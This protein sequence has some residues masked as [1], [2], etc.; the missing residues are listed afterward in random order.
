MSKSNWSKVAVAEMRRPDGGI[1][2]LA[3]WRRICKACG[4]V[5]EEMVPLRAYESHTFDLVNCREHRQRGFAPPALT[6]HGRDRVVHRAL[7]HGV[8]E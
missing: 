2:R 5:F 1:A 7:H 6:D 4:E 8:A 3:V